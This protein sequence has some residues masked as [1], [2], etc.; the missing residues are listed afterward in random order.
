LKKCNRWW[1]V[2]VQIRYRNRSSIVAVGGKIVAATKKARQ[3][4]SNVKVF[5][6]V[7]YGKGVFHYEFLPRGQ[8]VNGQFYMEVMKC[9][10]EAEWRKRPE[11]GRNKTWMLHR[12]NAPDHTSLFICQFLARHETTVVPQPPYSP[13]LALQTFFLFQKLKSTLKGRRFQ[14]I[15]EL[16]ENS[17]RDLCHPAKR[18][19]RH[20]PEL[21]NK[22]EAVYR[23]WRRILWRRHVLLICKLI[24]KCFKNKFRFLFGQ[25]T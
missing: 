1:N 6:I 23:Q 10:R 24:N 5:L 14:T 13:D 11:G 19:P 22:L 20:I 17:A 21:E 3:S 9:L 4:R 25:T 18:V 2:G 7:F 15:E 8:R 16:E 12:D